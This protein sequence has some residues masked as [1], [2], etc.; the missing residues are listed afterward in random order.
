[1]DP[2]WR[3]Q[4]VVIALG[5]LTALL[6]AH[7]AV[8][9]AVGDFLVVQDP[10]TPAD[11]VI[12]I[13]GDGEERVREASKLF[14]RG[15]GRWLL[16]SGGPGGGPGS[17]A[18]LLV[19]ARQ[20]QVPQVHILID[21]RATST[22]TNAEGAARVMRDAGLHTAIL[23]TSPYHMRRAVV[24]FR[25]TFQNAGFSVRAHPVRDGF[26]DVRKWWTRPP[27]RR[28]VLREYGK[29]LALLMGIY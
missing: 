11:V 9:Q 22:A 20:Y 23:V 6:L 14:A 12:A 18:E 25:R 13:S 26:F 28:I 1:M 4:V 27:E 19:Y 16:L 29:L 24:L 21:D 5:V 17:A 15:Y 3:R 7:R 2:R 10:L 8:L